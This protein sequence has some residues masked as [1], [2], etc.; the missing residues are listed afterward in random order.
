MISAV[1]VRKYAPRLPNLLVGMV[2]GSLVAIALGGAE[3]G[4]KLVGEIPAHLP[5]LSLP[6]LSLGSIKALAPQ[7][8]AVAPSAWI[9]R[10]SRSAG[11]S[12]PSR[13]RTSARTR[14]SSARACPTLSAVSFQLRRFRLVHALRDQLFGRGKDPD[15]GHFAAMM[16]MVIVLLIAP[17]TAYPPI[18]A[19]GGVILIVAYNPD[20]PAP[21]ATSCATAARKPASC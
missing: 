11:R 17:L 21:S 15:V 13:T 7:A 19:M 1:L 10:P 9:P 14:N 5:P 4:I 18:A 3:A 8:F 16:L 20:R 6:D 12:Q 2:V